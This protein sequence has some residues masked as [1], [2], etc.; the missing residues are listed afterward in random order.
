MY[1][2]ST[3]INGVI[4]MEAINVDERI[5]EF[6]KRKSVNTIKTKYRGTLQTSK[7]MTYEASQKRHLV[8]GLM[9]SILER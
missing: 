4:Q 8:S 6:L 5:E 7:W 1:Y 9:R 2:K 3:N